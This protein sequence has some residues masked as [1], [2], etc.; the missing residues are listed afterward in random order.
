MHQHRFGVVVFMVRRQDQIRPQR[1]E[2]P[3]P[4]FP[5]GLFDALSPFFRQRSRVKMKTAV[6]R[7]QP[8]GRFPHQRF[9]FGGLGPQTVVYMG[10][11]IA[12]LRIAA[13]DQMRH[14]HGIGAAGNR[15]NNAGSA[16]EYPIF[17]DKRHDFLFHDS[18]ITDFVPKSKKHGIAA[19]LPILYINRP[20]PPSP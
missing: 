13:A 17:F 12:V 4:F 20:L 6:L 18:I 1:A 19:F 8:T 7:F 2:K 16:P 5:T 15:Q 9:L 14:R 10:N 11:D 3:I